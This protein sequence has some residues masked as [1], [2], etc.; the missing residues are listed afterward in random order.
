[1]RGMRR[2]NGE[3]WGGESERDGEGKVRGM[4]RGK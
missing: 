3:G 2:G 4:R 1:M